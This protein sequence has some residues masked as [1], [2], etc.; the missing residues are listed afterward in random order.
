MSFWLSC[1]R[2]CEKVTSI[3]SWHP[4]NHIHKL[5]NVSQ[6]R[7]SNRSLSHLSLQIFR[8]K[9]IIFFWCTRSHMVVKKST[10]TKITTSCFSLSKPLTKQSCKKPNW[11]V[12]H[13]VLW[14][15]FS[16]HSTLSLYSYCSHHKLDLCFQHTGF[17]GCSPIYT[18]ILLNHNTDSKSSS[19]HHT[20]CSI[21]M[22][23]DTLQ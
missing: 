15:A 22:V 14:N 1:Q 21:F 16:V 9:V 12:S 23:K 13:K 2:L 19:Q 11:F 8:E 18:I 4:T 20:M 17:S 5:F 3:C 7:P 6:I 10:E